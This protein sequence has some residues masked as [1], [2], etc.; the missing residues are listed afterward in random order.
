MELIGYVIRALTKEVRGNRGKYRR[1]WGVMV[2]L[3]D[4]V[5]EA[6]GLLSSSG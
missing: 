4:G 2:C 6:G 1:M 5:G 3:H